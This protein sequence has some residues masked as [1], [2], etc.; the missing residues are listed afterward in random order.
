NLTYE[1]VALVQ[2][3]HPIRTT[4]LFGKTQSKP[5]FESSGLGTGSATTQLV[6]IYSDQPNLLLHEQVFFC[7]TQP[8][9]QKTQI[10]Q[11]KVP[12]VQDL[13]QQQL[14]Q[15][16]QRPNIR[17]ATSPSKVHLYI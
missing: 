17:K 13:V 4:S 14:S 10:Q 1:F 11:P 9:Q 3:Q 8:A 6:L 5:V 16:A 12:T 7:L 15:I 2:R